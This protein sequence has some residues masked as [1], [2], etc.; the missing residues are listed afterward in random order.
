MTDTYADQILNAAADLLEDV[1]WVQGNYGSSQTG[2]CAVGALNAAGPKVLPGSLY[3]N[4][5]VWAAKR[6][7]H[8]FIDEDSIPDWNDF[9]RRTKQEVI[10][11]LRKA[12]GQ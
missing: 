1:G 6:K 5:H 2:F 8:M 10:D 12:A 9:P 3:I 11:T 4:D 7:L